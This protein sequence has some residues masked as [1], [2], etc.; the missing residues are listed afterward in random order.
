M[1]PERAT[2]DDHRAPAPS[3][4]KERSS[5]RRGCL[6][7]VGIFAVFLVLYLRIFLSD[8]PPPEDSDLLPNWPQVANEVNGAWYLERAISAIDLQSF[9]DYETVLERFGSIPEIFYAD[10]EVVLFEL[11]DAWGTLCEQ[12]G[13]QRLALDELERAADAPEFVPLH[14]T[15]DDSGAITR[16]V[17]FIRQAALHAR[18]EGDPERARRLLESCRSI[19]RRLIQRPSSSTDLIHL[20]PTYHRTIGRDLLYLAL[21]E[22]SEPRNCGRA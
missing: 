10:P 1:P 22:E 14:A 20:I 21:T 15:V 2:E 6:V 3:P 4:P 7:A 16:F 5:R 19:L 9:V 13:A 12:I 18:L 11:K 17:P 8:G